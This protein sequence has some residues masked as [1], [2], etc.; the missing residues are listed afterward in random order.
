MD[1]IRI[2]IL[3]SKFEVKK[4][5]KLTVDKIMLYDYYMKFP[6]TMIDTNSLNV[7]M[8]YDFYEYYSFYHWKPI[9]GEYNKILKYLISKGFIERNFD[10]KVS[11]YVITNRGNEFLGSLSSIYKESL[12][13][14][15]D[16]VKNNI[17]KKSDREVENDILMKTSIIS[18]FEGEK[19]GETV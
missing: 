2:L 10:K 4:T 7:D 17:S 15:S 3:I 8:K 18:R 9:M 1:S 13:V 12:E 19:D 6:N 14:L 11:H 5:F 16:F